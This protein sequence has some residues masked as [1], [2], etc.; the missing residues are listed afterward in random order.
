MTNKKP[1]KLFSKSKNPYEDIN[2]KKLLN[3]VVIVFVLLNSMRFIFDFIAWQVAGPISLFFGLV[4]VWYY[5]K[6]NNI[7]W[8]LLGFKKEWL[9]TILWIFITLVIAL[10]V[11]IFAGKLANIFFEKLPR[12]NIR[13]GNLEG[14]I[15][16]TLSWVTLGIA[17]G[18]FGEEIVYRGF[19]VNAIEKL[20]NKKM[21]IAIAILLPAL[22][23]GLRHFYFSGGH[24]S[25][26]VFSIGLLFGIIYIINGRNIW[27]LIF[28][29]ALI[30]TSSFV[31]RY[32]GL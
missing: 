3:Q 27:P 8:R 28:V 6:K 23:W 24:G 7:T 2:N 5:N 30:D 9:K 21:G 11:I 10:F 29:H 32:Y 14:N 4:A 20:I 22:F 15:G 25:I 13:F 16:L 19:F 26:V 12:E 18:G 17:A 1:F 31:L